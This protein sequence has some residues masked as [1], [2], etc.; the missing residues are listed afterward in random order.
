MPVF[1]TLRARALIE[2]AISVGASFSYCR[3]KKGCT[4]VC[5]CV[6]VCVCVCVCA[7]VHVHAC[8]CARVCSDPLMLPSGVKVGIQAF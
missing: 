7:H 3:E 5:L 6:C 2:L 8:V 1:W 4:S